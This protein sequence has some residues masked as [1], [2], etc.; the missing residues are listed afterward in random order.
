MRALFIGAHYDDCELACAGTIARY[1][2]EN[3]EV[4][5]VVMTHSGYVRAVDG[6]TRTTEVARKESIDA[7]R[8]LG[9]PDENVFHLGL[10]TLNLAFGQDLVGKLDFVLERTQPDRIFTHWHADVHQDHQA[11]GKATLAAGRRCHGI[12]MYRSNWYHANNLFNETYYVDI[13][14]YLSQK[15][16]ALF[17]YQ[18]EVAKAG[19]DWVNFFLQYNK[20]LG[21]TLGVEAAEAYEIVKLVE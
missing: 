16:N 20:M 19:K 17:C 21:T 14:P 13:S 3:H 18:S 4:F 8:A 6:Y 5:C 1:V 2:A 11:V 12:L 9:V 10:P 15:E 7:L